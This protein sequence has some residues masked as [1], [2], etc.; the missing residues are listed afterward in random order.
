MK[1]FNKPKNRGQI[2]KKW[3]L[4]WKSIEI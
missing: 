2:S 1:Y 4:D 3:N